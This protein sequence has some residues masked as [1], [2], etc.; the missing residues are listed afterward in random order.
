MEFLQRRKSM[1]SEKKGCQICESGS[2]VEI[3]Y[4]DKFSN[5]L[6]QHKSIRVCSRCGFG[7]INPKIEK[8]KLSNYYENVYRSIDSVMYIDF[9][10]SRVNVNALDYRSLSQILLAGC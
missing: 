6:F 3:S 1:S 8:D 10:K 7:H 9:D 2:L 4:L 5:S